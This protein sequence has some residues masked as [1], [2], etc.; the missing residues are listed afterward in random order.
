MIPPANASLSR[1]FRILDRF[2]GRFL[3]LT[4]VLRAAS[5]SQTENSNSPFS[6]NFIFAWFGFIPIDPRI[7]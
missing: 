4:I 1:W 7:I 3:P 6:S 2:F 5:A